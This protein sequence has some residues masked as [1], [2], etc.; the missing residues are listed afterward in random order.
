MKSIAT[1]TLVC[2]ASI[3][4]AQSLQVGTEGVRVVNNGPRLTS[5]I[6]FQL[7]D[8]PSLDLGGLKQDPAEEF[9]ARNYY[10]K[11]ARLSNGNIVVI[12]GT[13]AH[14]F[15]ASGKRLKTFGRQGNG[16]GEFRQA[17]DV[18][19]ARGDTVLIAQSR[20]LVNR[21][22]GSG[23]LIDATPPGGADYAEGQFCF[24]DGTFVTLSRQ[25]SEFGTGTPT[26]YKAKRYSA[27][28]PLNVVAD[29]EYPAFDML[30]TNEL[31]K[32]ARGN[33]FY[34]G[35]P[36]SFDI[37]GYSADG[38]LE[39]LI[40][41]SDQFVEITDAEKQK[42]TP[43]AYRAGSTP[44]EIEQ[45]RKDAIAKSK[46]KYWPTLNQL[47][48]D[49]SGRIWVEERN[50]HRDPTK[51]VAWAAF[52]STGHLLGRLVIPGAPSRELYRIVM[53]FGVNEVYFR[54]NDEDGAPHLRIYPILPLRR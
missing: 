6:V 36:T 49:G 11:G 3:A 9:S 16:P 24:A 50:D 44:A 13:R 38:K 20:G 29:F 4:T 22:T 37:K 52:D 45:A 32:A 18:C 51:P 35:E 23:E 19:V 25:T 46:T 42:M 33:R 7:A 40:K 27:T 12:D 53:G 41:T 48:I 30:I 21:F 31:G 43:G 10:L 8:K 17:T 47:M 34:V 15:D 1:L 2:L 54:Q 26:P 28:R 14:I 5:P 39:L